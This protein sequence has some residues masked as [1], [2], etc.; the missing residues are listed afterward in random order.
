ML[1]HRF[2]GHGRLGYIGKLKGERM[3]DLLLQLESE[4]KKQGYTIEYFPSK[5]NGTS[6]TD[7]FDFLSKCDAIWNVFRY[8]Y[9]LSGV[10]GDAFMSSTPLI[11]SSYEPFKNM[12]KKN[13]LLIEIDYS[14]PPTIILQKIVQGINKCNIKPCD[15]NERNRAQSMFAGEKAFREFWL[16]A[17]E[18]L[19]AEK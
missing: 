12:L 9:I 3:P 15:G 13:N 8:P 14:E 17:F 4:L 1:L 2:D 10:T 19:E 18:T 7:K 11:V 5:S 16:K 6:Q